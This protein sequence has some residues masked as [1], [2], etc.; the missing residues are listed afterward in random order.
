MG[1]SWDDEYLTVKEIADRLTLNQQTVRNWIFSPECGVLPCGDWI[2]GR[3]V[4]VPSRRSLGL[5][6][7]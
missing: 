3:C 4:D 1:A 5:V 7:Q 2:R 6:R